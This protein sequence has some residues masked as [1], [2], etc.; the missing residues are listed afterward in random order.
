M[1]NL[2]PSFVLFT[3]L[4]LPGLAGQGQN[5][6]GQGQNGN[7]QGY[8]GVPGPIAGAGLP[9]IAIGYGIYW[10]I[11]QRRRRKIN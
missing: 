2:I 9:V 5:G 7:G 11:Q 3:A 4:C 10:L 1:K 8:Y 6:N